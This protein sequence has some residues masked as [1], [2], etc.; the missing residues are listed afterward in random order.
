MVRIACTTSTPCQNMW[1]GSKLHPI[2]PGA[3]SRS[4]IILSGVETTEV[5]RI[6]MATRTPAFFAMRAVSFQYGVTRCFHCHA[7]ICENSG[8]HGDTIHA[9]CPRL[10]SPGVHPLKGIT[11]H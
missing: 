6:S 10:S 8:G 11:L 3:M 7:S 9:G 5:G 4:R 2:V 1:L